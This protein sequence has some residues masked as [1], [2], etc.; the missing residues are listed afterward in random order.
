MKS[1]L[2]FVIIFVH[3]S[4]AHSQT[5]PFVN[6]INMTN[7]ALLDVYDITG[8][9]VPTGREAA[10]EGTSMIN[11]HF[12]KGV[13]KFKNGQQF[14]DVLLNLSLI[15]N[16]LYFRRDSTEVIFIIP[17]EQ[18]V[19]PVADGGKEKPS[20]F[21]SGYPAIKNL[22]PAS[23]F[24][25]LNEGSKL[26]LLKYRHKTVTEHYVYGGPVRN[27]YK[28]KSVLFIYKVSNNQI[29]EIGNNIKS[30]KKVLPEFE[31]AIDQFGLKNKIDFK[32]EEEIRSLV[33]YINNL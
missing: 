6:N 20:I 26:H 24:Q 14:K 4:I 32:K 23:F 28:L 18:F 27:E 22:S 7:G 13:V 15:N 17:V 19:L 5:D 16:R 11:E 9:K 3:H 31:A 2:L 21:R 29:V 10:V 8:K 12:E 30:L 33:Q 25:V 1:L